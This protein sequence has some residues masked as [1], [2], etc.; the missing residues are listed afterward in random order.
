MNRGIRVS[1]AALTPLARAQEILANNLANVSTTGFR[2][3]RVGF[4]RLL[5]A[6]AQPGPGGANA[7]AQAGGTPAPGAAGA[8]GGAGAS[9]AAP[10][11]GRR[12]DL[13][14]GAIDTTGGPL[15][16]ALVGPGF[17][18][19]Q[20]PD[21]PAYT[22]DGSLSLD[23]E[24][25]LVHRSGNPLLGEGGPITL[26]AGSLFEVDTDGTVRVDGEAQG[27][28]QVVT[29]DDPTTLRHAGR[30]LLASDTPGTPLETARVVQGSLESSNVDPVGTMVEMMTVLRSFEAN[31]N[32]LMT[33]DQTLAQLVRWAST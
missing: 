29:F 19:V 31:H 6:T 15:D 2:E 22:R 26:A 11:L 33:Q 12:V 17:F 18:T 10:A 9:L 7:G 8:G 32:A 30:G 28:L 5:A 13:E 20:T 23:P 25:Q 4:E 21:G 3:D 24:G 14:S 27:R 1:A 16:L